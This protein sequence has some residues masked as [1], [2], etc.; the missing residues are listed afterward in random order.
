MLRIRNSFFCFSRNLNLWPCGVP[1]IKDLIVIKGENKEQYRSISQYRFDPGTRKI[2]NS[3]TTVS[4]CLFLRQETTSIFDKLL[5]QVVYCVCCVGKT[6]N[7]MLIATVWV[8][9]IA[10]SSWMYFSFT[11]RYVCKWA[12]QESS[13]FSSWYCG[14]II[15]FRRIP[16]VETTTQPLLLLTGLDVTWVFSSWKLSSP[17]SSSFTC[18]MTSTFLSTKR[19]SLNYWNG[20]MISLYFT[21]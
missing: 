19:E 5:K 8:L 12:F 7:C 6:Y 16:L 14:F 4:C 11:N 10:L 20:A 2:T 1:Q 21:I 9:N 3:W 18:K 15:K 13:W 17:I